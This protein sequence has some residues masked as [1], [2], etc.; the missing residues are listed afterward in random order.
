[1]TLTGI[2]YFTHRAEPCEALSAWTGPEKPKDPQVFHFAF[3]RESVA[4]NRAIFLQLQKKRKNE[5]LLDNPGPWPF[6][7]V[8]PLVQLVDQTNLITH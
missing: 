7:R 1:M 5:G 3:I 2:C 4:C 6:S 8:L